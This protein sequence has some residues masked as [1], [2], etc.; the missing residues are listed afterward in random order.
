MDGERFDGLARMLGRG[1]SR[2]RMLGALMGAAGLLAAPSAPAK[3][4]EDRGRARNHTQ[5]RVGAEAA[6]NACERLCAQ[7]FPRA[8]RARDRCLQR[9]AENQAICACPGFCRRLYPRNPARQLACLR[10]ALA[11]GPESLCGQCGAD[12][13]LACAQAD[14][15][16]ICCANPDE[17][18]GEGACCTPRTCAT[19]CTCGMLD[20]GCGLPPIDC[21]QELCGPGTFCAV[22]P[23]FGIGC[24]DCAASPGEERC[25]TGSGS[26]CPDGDVSLPGGVGSGTGVCGGEGGSGGGGNSGGDGGGGQGPAPNP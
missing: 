17:I 18:C 14:G 25:S 21:N 3:R 9:A 26:A 23:G 13:I 16:H 24:C 12:P 2:R 11:D 7:L 19:G 6:E 20:P 4:L 1:L 5:R 8:D 15:S 10:A 22:R